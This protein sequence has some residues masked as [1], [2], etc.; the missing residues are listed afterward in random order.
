MEAVACRAKKA[1]AQL[2]AEAAQTRAAEDCRRA[3]WHPLM[4]SQVGLGTTA[5]PRL[6]LLDI[7]SNPSPK[8][9]DSSYLN[10]EDGHLARRPALTASPS[11]P[12]HLTHLP[13]K[14]L[15]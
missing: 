6:N 4:G 3:L 13:L 1:C 7:T 2:D 11:S 14:L 9:D 8:S 15:L 10:L 12:C 5:F